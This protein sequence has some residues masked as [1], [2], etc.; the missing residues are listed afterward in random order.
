MDQNRPYFFCGIGG[1]GM[2]PLALILRARGREV[3]G[4]DRALDQ[5]RTPPKFA[6]LRSRGIGLFPQDGSGVQDPRAIVVASAAVEDSVPDVKAARALGAELVTRAQL[7]AELFNAA[8]KSIGVAGT[9]GKTTTT[10]MIGWILHEAGL[11]PT[12]V[13]GGVMKNFVTPEMPFANA[14]AGGEDLFVCEVDESDGSIAYYKPRIAVLN[15]VALDHKS[16]DELR[17]LFRDF[18]SKAEIAVLNLDDSETKAIVQKFPKAIT[19]SFADA[20][21]RLLA[22]DLAFGAEQGSFDVRDRKSGASVHVGL[23]VP[24]QHNAANALAAMG[25][26]LACGVTTEKSALALSR[27]AGIRRR[28]ERVGEANGV[29]VIDDFAHNPDK[30]AA[31]LGTLHIV[32]GRLLLLFQ[33]QGYGPLRKMKREFIECFTGNMA[34]D[35]VLV[36]PEPVYFGGTVDRSVSSGDIVRGVEAAGRKAFALPDRAACGEKLLQLAR[37]GDRIVIM[38]ARDDTLTE[39]AAELLYKLQR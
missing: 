28:F 34:K 21:A 19:Y 4:S 24:G 38:G 20:N 23:Q 35:D 13:N 31:T 27:F 12:I 1:S 26:A 17:A 16:L 22:S 36:M 18:V 3:S 30:I 7:L 2:L 33:P 14:V 8:P 5:G 11:N 9:S 32:P 25:A 29:T 37:S 10:G 15:N 39:F 6:F